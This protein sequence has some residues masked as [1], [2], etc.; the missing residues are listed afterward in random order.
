MVL[1]KE[2]HA[3]GSIVRQEWRTNRNSDT[4]RERQ[5]RRDINGKTD[6][7]R[8]QRK[9]DTDRNI[10]WFKKNCSLGVFS[11]TKTTYDKMIFAIESTDKVLSLCKFWTYSVMVKIVK[12]RHSNGYIN[13]IHKDMKNL[14]LGKIFT[15]MLFQM[16]Q[17]F[18]SLLGH[19]HFSLHLFFIFMEQLFMN[20]PIWGGPKKSKLCSRPAREVRFLAWCSACLKKHIYND[21]RHCK[22]LTFFVVY[23]ETWT[24]TITKNVIFRLSNASAIR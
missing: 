6:K 19:L 12:T 24:E 16:Y 3:D 15:I 17:V 20:H 13:C 10:G 9:M 4:G 1:K 21:F 14:F 5:A 11:I 8:K 7:K 22:I 18:S 2:K 23:F